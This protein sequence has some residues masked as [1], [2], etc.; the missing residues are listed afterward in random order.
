MK[1]LLFFSA[2][3][4]FVSC[5]HQLTQSQDKYWEEI[6]HK[7]LQSSLLSVLEVQNKSLYNQVINDSQD[8]NLPGFWGQSFNFDSGAKKTILE[9]KLIAELQAKYNIVNDNKIVHAGI[10]HTYGY[11]F[12]TLNTPYGFKRKRWVE[13]TL[14]YGFN[15]AGKSISPNP[16]EGTLLS[17]ITYFAGK[18]AFSEASNIEKLDTLKNVSSEIKN[19]SYS[20]TK[21]DILDEEINYPENVKITLRT[22]IVK[23]FQKEA[24]EEN[25]YLLIYSWL[26]RDTKEEKLITAFPIKRDAYLKTLDI[27]GLGDDRPI[28]VRYNGHIGNDANARYSGKRLIFNK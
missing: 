24:N 5:S 26:N 21:L 10:M 9:D 25:D 23:F 16:T 15:L 13:P 17:N 2:L 27:Q 14:S 28:L 22:T 6:N 11:L 3:L 8:L 7:A 1:K 20:K 12:S 4:N 18:L 19:F